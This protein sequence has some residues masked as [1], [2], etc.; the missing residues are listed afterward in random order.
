MSSSTRSPLQAIEGASEAPPSY[1]SEESESRPP[2]YSASHAPTPQRPMSPTDGK[3]S[4]IGDFD[5][6]K[7]RLALER[8]GHPETE[9]SS[10]TEI[11]SGSE[12]PLIESHEIKILRYYDTVIVVDDSLS[13]GYGASEKS[14]TSLTRW[15]FVRPP[16]YKYHTIAS[17]L[18]W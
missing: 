8:L 18:T 6:E 15:R 14:E 1:G 3:Y 12:G 5:A 17:K 7:Q 11:Q 10:F 2:L 13:M 9:S 16:H 4:S